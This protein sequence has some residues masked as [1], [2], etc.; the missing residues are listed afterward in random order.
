[1]SNRILRLPEVIERTG[2]A[3]STI[4]K[5]IR[6]GNFPAQIKLTSKS[7]GWREA[8]IDAWIEKRSETTA[9]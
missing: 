7:V 2:L 4:Y 1:M 5:H 9:A 6:E 8:D 3:T